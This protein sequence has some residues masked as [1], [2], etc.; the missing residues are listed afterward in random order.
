[1]AEEDDSSLLVLLVETHARLWSMLS[2]E[3]SA[4]SSQP[5]ALSGTGYLTQVLAFVNTFLML[6]EANRVAIF[7]TD[8]ADSHLLYQSPSLQNPTGRKRPGLVPASAAAETLGH[9]VTLL[10]Q[11]PS[12]TEPQPGPVLSAALSRALCFIHKAQHGAAAPSKDRPRPRILCLHGSPDEPSQY[13]AIMNA[14]FAAQKHEVVIDACMVADVDSAFL[15]QAAHLTHGV[16]LHPTKRAAL[17]QHLLSVFMCDTFSR[18]FLRL[19]KATGVDFRASCFCHKRLIDLGFVCSVCLSI[20]CQAS[21]ECTTCGTSF[22]MARSPASKRKAVS[23][24]S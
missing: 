21:S 24:P 17:L 3:Q 11:E 14:I 1:M 19:P 8:T 6:N 13:I 9:L 4:G 12:S 15:Q 7:A 2:P 10:E 16:Y 18:S 22:V 5:P 23:P 20:F